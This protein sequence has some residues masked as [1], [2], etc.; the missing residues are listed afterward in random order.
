MIWDDAL[1][2]RLI[3][4][5]TAP[6][7]HTEAEIAGILSEERG[8]VVSRNQVHG[9]LMGG[10]VNLESLESEKPIPLYLPYYTKYIEY[11]EDRKIAEPKV[12]DLEGVKYETDDP[13]KILKV[14]DFHIPFENQDFIQTAVNRNLTADVIVMDEVMDC[15]ALS[16]FTKSE[17]IPFEI[18]LDRTVRLYEYLSEKFPNSVIILLNTNHSNR[19]SKKASDIHESLRFL[20][21]SDINR[22]LS[23]PF[24]NIIPVDQWFVQI[25]DAI[26]CHCERVS[27]AYLTRSGS[28]TKAFAFFTD[29]K[30]ALGLNDFNIIAQ[31]HTHQVNVSYERAGTCKIMETGCL[32]KPLSYPVEKAY[33]RPQVAGYG[34]VIQSGGKSD[35][36]NSRE[37]VLPAQKYNPEVISQ[38]NGWT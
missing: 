19:V 6:E 33:G 21:N 15:Y 17:N 8:V 34:V 30:Y 14:G 29:W 20:V 26:F 22:V 31:G 1:T 12:I 32:C 37:Y 36:E 4:L 3:E 35:I 24:P 10:G 23:R 16:R 11:F 9:K 13:I 28:V 27:N 38:R 25:N 2:R 5:K 18:E 7:K